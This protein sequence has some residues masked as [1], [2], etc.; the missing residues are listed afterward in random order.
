LADVIAFTSIHASLAVFDVNGAFFNYSSH[1]ENHLNLKINGFGETLSFPKSFSQ[2]DLEGEIQDA[3]ARY[4]I[5]PHHL[6]RTTIIQQD[7]TATPPSK[8]L[9]KRPPI[10]RDH[11][12]TAIDT[13]RTIRSTGDSRN[14]TRS[15]DGMALHEQRDE[16]AK[17]SP[18]RTWGRRSGDKTA[19]SDAPPSAWNGNI[20]SIEQAPV[21]PPPP[22]SFISRRLTKSISFTRSRPDRYLGQERSSVTVEGLPDTVGRQQKQKVY[23]GQGYELG[24]IL[25]RPL[26]PL[27]L[28]LGGEMLDDPKEVI[29][30]SPD[31]LSPETPLSTKEGAESEDWHGAGSTDSHATTVYAESRFSMDSNCTPALSMMTA[32]FSPNMG[33]VRHH[34][35]PPTPHLLTPTATHH[36]GTQ[37]ELLYRKSTSARRPK[38]QR[39]LAMSQIHP[40]GLEDELGERPPS[41]QEMVELVKLDGKRKNRQSLMQIED[42]MAFAKV[43]TELMQ[44]EKDDQAEVDPE[45]WTL[46][47]GLGSPSLEMTKHTKTMRAFFLVRELLVGERNYRRHL[48]KGIEVSRTV[49][50]HQVNLTYLYTAIRC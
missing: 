47:Q 12:P 7:M 24:Y 22:S 1:D 43:V 9:V 35:I 3:P 27:E 49:N 10:D 45:G 25:L 26:S 5:N 46:L 20:V 41:E 48:V 17:M 13:T 6:A 8:K 31:P 21:L 28:P 14:R 16:M 38:L 29:V 19:R 32:S 42:D 11:K 30:S 36:I 23:G 33:P 39:T 4:P 34:S 15:E 18:W 2:H 50:P 37:S 44:A 40:N